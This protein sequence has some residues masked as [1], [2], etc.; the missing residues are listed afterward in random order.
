MGAV[1]AD[2]GAYFIGFLIALFFL[3]RLFPGIAKAK[4]TLEPTGREMLFFSI[5]TAFTG[6]FTVFLTW[7]DRL[8]I[9][10]SLTASDAGIFQAVS[11]SSI[12]FGV[13]LSAFN[14][15]FAPMIADLYHKQE[16]G[17]L[18]ELF[19]ISTK[20]ALYVSLPLFLVF[21]FA[22]QETLMLVFGTPFGEGAIPLMILAVSQLV[23]VGT[24]A[25][26]FLLIM[27]GHQKQW[28]YTSGG[29]LIVNLIMN[30]MLIPQFGLVGA[31]IVRS[32]SIMALFLIGLFQVRYFLNLW[33]YDRRYFKGLLAASIAAFILYL[34]KSANVNPPALYLSLVILLAVGIFAGLLLLLGLDE[35]DR[36]FIRLAKLRIKRFQSIRE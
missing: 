13:I 1:L 18:E 31:A 19:R 30:W 11:Q 33:P 34:L 27:S 24:G 22:P 35:E 29:V 14:A 23:D 12:A 6:L 32:V 25:V 7:T 10:Y 21:I 28:L 3:W 26:S 15:I 36:E 20:W 5:P 9:G 16:L 4:P 17:R 8:I 2:I